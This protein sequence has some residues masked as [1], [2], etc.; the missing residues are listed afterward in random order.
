MA[1]YDN[2]SHS[3]APAELRVHARPWRPTYRLLTL[4][5]WVLCAYL[6]WYYLEHTGA[7]EVPAATQV[8]RWYGLIGSVLFG[9]LA[10]YGLRR[11]AY[12]TSIGRLEWWYRTHLVLG[13][14]ALV[15]LA[16]HSGFA[17]R[18][19]FLGALQVG[20]WGAVLTGAVGWAFQTAF[21]QWMV[22]HEERPTVLKELDARA[23]QL[24]QRLSAS[25]ASASAVAASA[26]MHPTPGGLADPPEEAP[27]L[28]QETLNRILQQMS[29]RRFSQ[30]S[31]FPGWD[32]WDGQVEESLLNSGL[33][34]L[35]ADQRQWLRELNRTEVQ[36]SYHRA[37]RWWTTVHLLF[38]A[39]GVQ[40]MI[41]HILSVAG[42]PR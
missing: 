14:V 30:L 17:F 32:F 18:S 39:L 33:E 12:R 35:P 19:W 10:F 41:W 4:A 15:I 40:M 22:A 28:T 5:A 21:K 25:C 38:T 3:G 24:L 34:S 16:C 42:S 29:T 6:I 9:F 8:G 31:Y 26:E 11:V 37:L 36:R 13:L 7:A 23:E 1:G 2:T 20:F 27:A